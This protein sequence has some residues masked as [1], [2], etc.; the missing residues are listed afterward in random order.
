MNIN[1]IFKKYD[2]KSECV[3]KEWNGGKF[4]IAP[5]GN[6]AQQKEMLNQF[7]LQE[8]NDFETKGPMVFGAM[9]AGKALEKIYNLYASTIIFDWELE[10]DDGKKIPFSVKK[11]AELMSEHLDFGNWVLVAAQ[12]VAEEKSKKEEELEKK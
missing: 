8:A 5:Q 9:M 2:P 1:E 6:K 11:C 4:F 12:E 10:A 3:W 7:T